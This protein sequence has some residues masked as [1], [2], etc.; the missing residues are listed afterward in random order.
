MTQPPRTPRP[1]HVAAYCVGLATLGVCTY[2][3]GLILG[4]LFG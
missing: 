1:I 2:F 4:A 3:M